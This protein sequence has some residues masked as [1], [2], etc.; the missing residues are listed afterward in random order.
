MK[1]WVFLVSTSMVTFSFFNVHGCAILVIATRDILGI[2]SLGSVFGTSFSSLHSSKSL[3]D[4]IDSFFA[5]QVYNL[6]L[7]H[8]FSGD[9][10]SSQYLHLFTHFLSGSSSLKGGDTYLL[11]LSLEYFDLS[12]E[13]MFDLSG[14][15]NDGLLNLFL[16][17]INY[18]TCLA[19]STDL[20]FH[21]FISPRM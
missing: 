21:S 8:L 3:L 18:A 7:L 4:V 15:V 12:F 11:N 6:L 20:G 9:H 1:L 19:S 14:P 16:C 13:Y 5:L 17:S 2:S 10:L